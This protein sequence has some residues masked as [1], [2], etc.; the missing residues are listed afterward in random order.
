VPAKNVTEYMRVRRANRRDT[1][2]AMLGGKCAECGATDE[3]EFDHIDPATKLFTIGTRLD[4]RWRALLDEVAKCQLLCR[5]HHEARSLTQLSVEHGGG[6]SGKKNCPC[7][8]CKARKAEYMHAYTARR[9]AAAGDNDP[10]AYLAAAL[11]ELESLANEASNEGPWFPNAESDQVM[12]CRFEEDADCDHEY[13]DV[14]GD[15]FSLSNR[16]LRGNVRLICANDPAHVLRMVAAHREL[17]E[18]HGDEH[19]CPSSPETYRVFRIG[20]PPCETI[21]LLAGAYGWTGG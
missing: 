12:C 17:L 5:P 21:K 1:L 4:G 7:A 20:G 6:A 19:E 16:V 8:P 14:L 18:L 2:R 13:C 15:G 9:A 11:D 3:L 10:A